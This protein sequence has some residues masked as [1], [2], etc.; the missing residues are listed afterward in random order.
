MNRWIRLL[1]HRWMDASDSRRAVPDAM[2]E[3]LAQRVTA[4]ERR[5]TG[6]VRICVE[7]SLPWSQAW[8]ARDDRAVR[9]LGRQRALEWFGRLRIWDTEA[10][11]DGEWFVKGVTEDA[12]I[13][14]NSLMA[15]QAY[16]ARKQSA[17]EALRSDDENQEA[18]P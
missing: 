8:Q 12:R 9:V 14:A 13:F 18:R 16:I 1:K 6:E 11:Y 4:S 3:R 17:R 10:E 7:A 2:A 5:H 15:L